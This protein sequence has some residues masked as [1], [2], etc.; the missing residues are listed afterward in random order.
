MTAVP[1]AGER[2]K[3]SVR[4]A[5]GGCAAAAVAARK[6]RLVMDAGSSAPIYTLSCQWRQKSCGVPNSTVPGACV[7]VVN[8]EL[9]EAMNTINTTALQIAAGVDLGGTAVN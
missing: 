6:L 5:S 9:R 4:T 3:I 7:H 1:G 2:R 8:L